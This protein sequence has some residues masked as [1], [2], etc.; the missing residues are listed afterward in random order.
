MWGW[1]SALLLSIFFFLMEKVKYC[2]LKI[3]ECGTMWHI[4]NVEGTITLFPVPMP[5]GFLIT[6]TDTS[7]TELAVSARKTWRIKYTY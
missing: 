7:F 6:S 5:Q 3:Q 2:L 1:R 4:Q